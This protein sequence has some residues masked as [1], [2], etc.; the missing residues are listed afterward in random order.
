MVY[1]RKRRLQTGVFYYVV[2]ARHTKPIKC[3]SGREGKDEANELASEIRKAR[4]D[5]E[6][7]LPI[8]VE[9]RW[10]FED[11]KTAHLEDARRRGLRTAQPQFQGRISYLESRWNNILA[12]FDKH[13]PLSALT[14]TRIRGFIR[15]RETTPREGRKRVAGPIPINQDL[16]TVLNPALAIARAAPESGFAGNPFDGIR[17]LVATDCREPVALPED[18]LDDVVAACWKRHPPLGAYVE[19][20][21]ETA[22]RLNEEP[23]IDGDLL[24]YPPY[25]RGRERVF[26]L[27]DRLPALMKA[28]RSFSRRIWLD[29]VGDLDF[30]PHD[31]RHSFLTILGKRPGMSLLT[32]MNY[33]GWQSPSMAERYLHPGTAALRPASSL[34]RLQPREQARRRKKKPRKRR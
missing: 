25:K 7:G 8:P 1:V 19:L 9:C 2:T 32:L 16:F 33:G 24:R 20:L 12:F 3:G 18:E 17:P 34:P 14:S 15:W 22:S 10:T 5:L 6:A 11:L 30:R 21:R 26:T 23:W 13:E 4:R 28:P 27:T 31:I 29:V